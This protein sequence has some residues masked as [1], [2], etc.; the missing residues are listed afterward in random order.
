MIEQF[1]LT[2]RWN[3]SGQSNGN[4]EILQTPGQVPHH[5][6][7]FSVISRRLKVLFFSTQLTFRHHLLAPLR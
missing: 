3:L 4:E 7:Q 1:Y 6:T 2:Q 5:Q